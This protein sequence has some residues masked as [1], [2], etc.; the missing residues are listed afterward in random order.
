ML[1]G[2]EVVA[3]LEFFADRSAE[4]DP[5]L[6]E[7]MAHVGAQLGRVVERAGRGGTAPGQGGAEAASRA[8]SVFLANMSHELRT[9]LNAII[10]FTRLVMRR[11]KDVLPSSSTR[12]WRRS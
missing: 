1:V 2:R 3:V 8:K 12:T 4:P 9:P 11:S 7:V 6:L 5:A 10:G